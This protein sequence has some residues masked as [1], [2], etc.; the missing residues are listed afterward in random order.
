LEGRPK[1]TT[2]WRS[3]KF[4]GQ[5][6]SPPEPVTDTP[7][8]PAWN[9]VLFQDGNTTWLF[10]KVGPRPREWIAGYWTSPDGG[11]TWSPVEYL[12]AGLIGPVRAKPTRG[13]S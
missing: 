9:P 10:F 6:W 2:I 8:L 7:G 1:D 3:V 4:P 12:P 11:R 5:S 13:T